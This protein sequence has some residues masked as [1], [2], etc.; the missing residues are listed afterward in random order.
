VYHESRQRLLARA[1]LI[2]LRQQARNQRHALVQWPVVVE[3]AR[4]QFD[5][6][7]ADLDVRIAAVE[8]E[9]ESVL[10]DGAWAASAALVTSAPG[11]GTI[12]A[13][14]WLVTTV[15]FTLA[16]SPAALAAYAG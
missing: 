10:A 5:E 4:R 3:A 13:A 6:V 16:P 12:T 7:V 15:D 9:L 8:R 1:A 11:I 2:A 14:W